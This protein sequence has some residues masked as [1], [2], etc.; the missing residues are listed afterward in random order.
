MTAGQSVISKANAE[1]YRWGQT[2]DGWYLVKND[3]LNVIEERM[4]PGTAESLHMHVKARQFFYVIAGTAVMEHEGVQTTIAAGAGIEIP[5][6]VSHRIM[7]KG[8][9]DLE[10]LVT[11]MPPSHSDRVEMHGQ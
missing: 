6:G 8:D 2:C 9:S 7:N 10:I 3:Q 5:P 11:S 1:H 4:P